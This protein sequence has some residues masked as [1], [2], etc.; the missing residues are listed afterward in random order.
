MLTN[1]T[2]PMY[3]IS[4]ILMCLTVASSVCSGQISNKPQTL[5]NKDFKWTITIPEG[6]EEV[7][8]DD[9]QRFQTRGAEVVED[10]Y[11]EKVE[12]LSTII[13]VYKKGQFNYLEANY[14][15]FDPEIDGDYSESCK[16]VNEIIFET[17]RTQI[18][19]ARLDS[20]SSVQTI[21]GL[22]FQTFDISIDLLNGV[23]LKSLLYCRL[24]GERDFSINIMYAE[25]EAGRKM[26]EAWVKSVFR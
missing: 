3:H 20:V 9:W 22:E 6:F 8:E 19:T 7:S 14:Q 5:R 24:F 18:P 15:P 4:S 2:K 1:S 23:K 17:F 25:K 10:T 13:F 12:N 11:G 16:V 26:M 21:S